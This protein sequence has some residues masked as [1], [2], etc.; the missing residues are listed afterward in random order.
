MKKHQPTPPPFNPEELYAK[1]NKPDRGQRSHSQPEVVYAEV[2][3][4]NRGQRSH[5]QPENNPYAPQKPLNPENAYA[6]PRSGPKPT[7]LVSPYAVRDLKELEGQPDPYHL[8]NPLYDGNR[9]QHPPRP[10]SEHLY[11]ELEFGPQRGQQPSK[12]VESVYATAGMGSG[13]PQE[14][15]LYQGVEKIRRT[16][17]PRTQQDLVTSGLAQNPNFQYGILEVQEWCAVVYGNRHALNGD[18]AKILANPSQGEEVLQKLLE[19]PESHAKLAGQKVF[20]VKSPARREAED[21]FRPLCA[22][23]ERHIHTAQKL[24]KDL[25]KGL[26]RGEGSPEHGHHH[27]HHHR[28]HQQER[29]RE[30]G[31]QQQEQSRSRTPSP[32]GAMAYAM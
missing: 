27:H 28:H 20:G 11:A 2:K 32:K 26:E 18:L 1:V 8:E 21:G 12:P 9:G 5:S 10:Q 31:A 16:S 19:N 23:L 4:P 3:H 25:T 13:G 6:V 15:T 7:P 29:G 24:H 14:N 22:A 30:R 17:P